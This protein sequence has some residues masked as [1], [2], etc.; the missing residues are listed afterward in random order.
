MGAEISVVDIYKPQT[1]LKYLHYWITC[2]NMT[3]LIGRVA[4]HMFKRSL[5]TWCRT[6]TA[7]DATGLGRMKK[8]HYRVSCSLKK[9]KKNPDGLFYRKLIRQYLH[10]GSFLVAS[11]SPPSPLS[12]LLLLVYLLHSHLPPGLLSFPHL[13]SLF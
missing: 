10:P 7:G 4:V 1:R 5:L 12:I 3:V 8:H 6:V 11:L 9:K 2:Y 13:V